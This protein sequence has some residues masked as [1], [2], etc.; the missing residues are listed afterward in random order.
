MQRQPPL[1]VSDVMRRMRF[2]VGHW[3][4]PLAHS[5]SGRPVL[6]ADRG[7]MQGVPDAWQ[8]P[9]PGQHQR[10]EPPSAVERHHLG[11]G[12]GPCWDFLNSQEGKLLVKQKIERQIWIIANYHS[13]IS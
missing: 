9:A 6:G 4:V 2:L 8:I 3:L 11:R 7:G 5:D 13:M 1:A 10:P 12:A